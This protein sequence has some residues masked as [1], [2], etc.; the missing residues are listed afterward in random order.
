MCL[1][2]EGKLPV[3]VYLRNR[4]ALALICW[5]INHGLEV[6]CKVDYIMKH[7]WYIYLQV[8]GKL[9]FITEQFMQQSWTIKKTVALC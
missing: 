2:F 3:A 9:W 6:S 8:T 1:W 4:S 5:V 7:E